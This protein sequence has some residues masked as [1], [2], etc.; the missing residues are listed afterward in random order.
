VEVVRANGLEIAVERA[1]DGPPL[2]LVHGA[3]DDSRIWQP[4]MYRVTGG[5]VT[6]FKTVVVPDTLVAT[7]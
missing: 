7:D 2:V 6:T 4:Q 3:G 1:G 5:K